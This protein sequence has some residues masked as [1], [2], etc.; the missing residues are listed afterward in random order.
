MGKKV[1]VQRQVGCRRRAG[2]AGFPPPPAGEV[3]LG[4]E[5]ERYRLD[6]G[7]GPLRSVTLEASAFLYTAAMQAEDF[8]GPAPSPLALAVT[9]ISPRFGPGR[10]ASAAVSL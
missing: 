7:A 2:M 10:T 4:E 9:Q 1:G 3:A 5:A 8:G 6:I